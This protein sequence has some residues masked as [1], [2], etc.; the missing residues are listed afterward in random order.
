MWKIFTQVIYNIL[1][2]IIM[3]TT[4]VFAGQALQKHN[5]GTETL[6]QYDFGVYIYCLVN[7]G[8]IAAGQLC[9]TCANCAKLFAKKNEM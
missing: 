7:Y 1:A 8:L 2:I 9:Q 5:A 3:I 4:M 6:K